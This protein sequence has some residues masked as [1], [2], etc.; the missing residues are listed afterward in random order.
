MNIIIRS[1]IT[2]ILSLIS[3]SSLLVFSDPS[4]AS[5]ELL[6]RAA[7]LLRNRQPQEAMSAAMSAPSS[8]QRSMIAGVAAFKS[9][10]YEDALPLLA[11][12]ERSYPVLADYAAAYRADALFRLKRYRDALLVMGSQPVKASPSTLVINWME[13]LRADALFEAG[14]IRG[15]MHAYQSYMGKHSLGRYNVDSRYQLARCRDITGDHAGAIAEYRVIWLQYPASAQSGKAHEY[16]KSSEKSGNISANRFTVEELMRRADLLMVAGRNAEAAWTLASIPRNLISDETLAQIELK[17]GQAAMKQ[18]QFTLADR[19]LSRSAGARN[20]QVRDEASLA[21]AKVESK[22]GRYDKAL[23]RLMLMASERGQFADNALFE[24][25]MLHKNAG[26]FAESLKLL[27]RL[28]KDFP[29][30]EVASKAAWEMAWC[31]YLS[32]DFNA[33]DEGFRRLVNEDAYREK[34]LYWSGR[35]L[36]KQNRQQDADKQFRQLL[37]EYP[38]GFYSAMRREQKQIQSGWEH[39]SPGVP[40][41]PLPPETERIQALAQCG[42]TDQVR[43]ELSALKGRLHDRVQQIMPGLVRLHQ[44]AGDYHGAISTF[45]QNR[46]K[47]IDRSN[48]MVWSMGYPRHYGELFSRY[49]SANSLS[50][51]MVLSLSKAESNFMASVKSPAGAIGLM[52]MMPATA[53]M[54]AKVKGKGQFNPLLLTEPDLNI[55]LGTRYLRELLDTYHQ[56]TVYALAAYNAGSGTVNRWRTSFGH[57]SRD[58]FVE[59]IPYRETRDYVKKIIGYMAVYRAVYRIN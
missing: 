5:G 43:A 4:A 29:K 16:L 11:D 10:R 45:H 24:A 32:S 46:P 52:Q 19:F 6:E 17:S 2:S 28:Q 13:K 58:E 15:A 7:R 30:S 9:G 21:L 59:N 26:R 25:A 20:R 47:T 34:S 35:S 14:D 41:P 22:T 44:M 12:A 50:E 49:A 55:K 42:M 36:E 3:I 37:A 53:R 33:A 38:F 18:R 57:L 1:S 56:D 31:R 51:A 23:S 40:E 39:Y 8:G 54:A 48:I 27:E